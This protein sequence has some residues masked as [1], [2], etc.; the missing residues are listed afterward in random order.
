[1]EMLSNM[2][3][4]SNRNIFRVS[5]PL[6]G[7]FTGHRWIPRT[8][9][10]DAELWC[11]IW[12]AWINRWVND[13][14]AGDL[15]RH[16]SHYDVIVME[17][18]SSSLPPFGSAERCVDTCLC[19]QQHGP[20]LANVFRWIFFGGT[21][22]WPKCYCGLVVCSMVSLH[23]ALIQLMAWYWTDDDPLYIYIYIYMP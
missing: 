21:G 19:P 8:K 18:T 2:M 4:S 23:S 17:S 13:R 1:M 6:C 3:T 7:E 12:S 14:Q 5:G 10:S 22:F 15:R 11:F 16:R 9:A 20:I